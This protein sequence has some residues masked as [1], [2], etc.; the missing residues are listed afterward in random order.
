MTARDNAKIKE[1]MCTVAG[2]VLCTYVIRWGG[3]VYFGRS[4]IRSLSIVASVRIK[5]EE[6][7]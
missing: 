4:R 1:N 2:I 5:N 6:K 7:H 3:G